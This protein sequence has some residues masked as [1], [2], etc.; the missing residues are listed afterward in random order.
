MTSKK[1][2]SKKSAVPASPGAFYQWIG[3]PLAGLGILA[4]LSCFNA[5]CWELWTYARYAQGEC[6]IV[7]AKL[8]GIYPYRLEVEHQIEGR[9]PTIYTEQ[10]TPKYY[11][12]AEA[13][14]QLDK[15]YPVGAVRPCFYDPQSD[16]SVLVA[17]GIN[18]WRSLGI[19][20]TSLTVATIGCWCLARGT[21]QT[22]EKKSPRKFR[23]VWLGKKPS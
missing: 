2:T 7:S 15:R 14:D 17:D 8:I 23:P 11:D 12:Q 9:K 3:W 22:T 5:V 13:Q 21:S 18:P 10:H 4:T 6:R 1:N 16:Y 19:L 20:G